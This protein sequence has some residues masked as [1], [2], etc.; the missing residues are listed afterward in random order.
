MKALRR[1]ELERPT[2]ERFYQEDYD[3][4]SADFEG[5]GWHLIEQPRDE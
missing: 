3:A 2:L 4:L 5:L 1:I